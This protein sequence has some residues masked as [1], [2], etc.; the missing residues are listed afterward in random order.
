MNGTHSAPWGGKSG[1]SASQGA[2]KIIGGIDMAARK[3]RTAQ[4]QNL[5]DVGS[6]HASCQQ[7]ARYPQVHD[8]PVRLRESLCDVPAL[9]AGLIDLGCL[10]AGWARRSSLRPRRSDRRYCGT[11][12]VA[13]D[14]LLA[15][16]LQEAFGLAGQTGSCLHD[17]HPWRMPVALAAVGLLIVSTQVTVFCLRFLLTGVR[18]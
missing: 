12:C 6:R 4:S 5:L 14:G 3:S 15:S 17:F 10:R 11:G 1:E 7:S 13:G 8:A 9:H 16:G 18:I 2:P